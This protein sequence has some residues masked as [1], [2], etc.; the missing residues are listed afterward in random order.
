ME[1]TRGFRCPVQYRMNVNQQRT[2]NIHRTIKTIATSLYQQQ[3][4]A[5]TCQH[6]RAP[7]IQYF[8][9]RKKGVHDQAV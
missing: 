2:I 6:D 8:I 4:Q 1:L 7:T 9:A 3:R 5:K